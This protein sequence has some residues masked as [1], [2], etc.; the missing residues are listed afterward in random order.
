MISK[1]IRQKICGVKI[2]VYI[3][4]SKQSDAADSAD[5]KINGMK[6]LEYTDAQ[7][8]RIT[9]DWG[10]IAKENGELQFTDDSILFFGSEIATLRLFRHYAN[11]VNR[12]T[13]GYSSN[14]DSYYFILDI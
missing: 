9:R 8:A 5:Y 11:L 10:N 6:P 1:K 3:C 7:K 12:V 13:Q 14:L 4:I 2:N